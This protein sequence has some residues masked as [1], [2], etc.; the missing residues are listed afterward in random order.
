MGNSTL[1]TGIPHA[2]RTARIRARKNIV[3]SGQGNTR[4]CYC[5]AGHGTGAQRNGVIVR[6]NCAHANSHRVCAYCCGIRTGRIRMEVLRSGSV[7]VLN[8]VVGFSQLR[9]V[10]R[11]AR[12]AA[13]RHVSDGGSP[14]IG[15][16]VVSI[17]S[18]GD[19]TV[20][21]GTV[22]VEIVLYR[23]VAQSIERGIGRVELRTVNRISAG[24]RQ[25]ARRHVS[26]GTLRTF[27]TDADRA[28]RCHAGKRVVGTVKGHPF[29]RHGFSRD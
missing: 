27:T 14:L 24:F 22:L 5:A 6:G 4:A 10:H 7:E 2:D 17:T 23:P 21:Y 28:G 9:E 8:I 13:I 15:V 20:V 25:A 1:S 11:I 19:I 18:Q 16:L 3:G 29:G 26:Q 12:R